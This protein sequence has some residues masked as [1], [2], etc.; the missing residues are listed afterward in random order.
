[1][2]LLAFV[3]SVWL[4]SN[5]S[6]AQTSNGPDYVLVIDGI[7]HLLALDETK[8]VI[9]KSGVEVPVK[10]SKREF[11][12][13]TTGN[14]TFAYPGKYTVAS[15]AVTDSTT[16]HIVVTALGTI[17]LVQ[18]YE[19]EIPSGLLNVMFDKMVEEAKALAFPIER[20][21]LSRKISNGKTM[22]GVRAHYKGGDDDVTIDI[23]VTPSG[24]GGFLVLTMHDNYTSPEEKQ[25]I[26]QFWETLALKDE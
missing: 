19:E 17:M 7:E 22:K 20:I 8:T 2:R 13:F 18:N 14:L 11:G 1:M 25:I 21:E 12:H 5:C 10:V 15:T 3:F 16:Q 26:E 6:W 23:T 24:K 4:S 9:L